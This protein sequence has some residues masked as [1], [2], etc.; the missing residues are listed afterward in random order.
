MTLPVKHSP[1]IF[2]KYKPTVLC[3]AQRCFPLP[4]PPRPRRPAGVLQAL[5]PISH[6]SLLQTLLSSLQSLSATGHL[7]LAL[8]LPQPGLLLSLLTPELAPPHPSG[9]SM[10]S[11]SSH[12]IPSS[13]S[14]GD[15]DTPG[16]RNTPLF[17][18]VSAVPG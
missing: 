5:S 12:R 15:R 10:L 16:I 14:V 6:P 7:L 9:L 8:S 3:G 2:P 18:V 17:G 1:R 11:A 13:S 4:E